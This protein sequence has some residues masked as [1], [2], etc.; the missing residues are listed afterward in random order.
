MSDEGE[1]GYGRPPKEHRFK[2]GQS[3][4]PNGRPKKKAAD[5]GRNSLREVLKRAGEQTVTINGED[6]TLFEVE[7]RALQHKAAKG[8]VAAS[9]HL[10]KLRAEAGMLKGPV[11]GTGVLVVPAAPA[12]DAEWEARAAANQAKF[13]GQDPEGLAR[14]EAGAGSLKRRNAE[15]E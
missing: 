15:E 13:R 3:G 7:V 8:D 2:K 11:P 4:N 9:R 10:A 1:V 12:S 14:L 6:I 5:P